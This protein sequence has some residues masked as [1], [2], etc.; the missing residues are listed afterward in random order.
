MMQEKLENI[1]KREVTF[2]EQGIINLTELRIFLEKNLEKV[3]KFDFSDA[4][5]KDGFAYLFYHS[6][7]VGIWA[8]KLF[9]SLSQDKEK[10]LNAVLAGF[11]HDIAFFQDEQKIYFRKREL[12][13]EEIKLIKSHPEKG[14]LFLLPVE[15][16]STMVLNGVYEHHERLDGSGYPRGIKGGKISLLGRVLAVC[17]VYDALQRKHVYRGA[18]YGHEVWVDMGKLSRN[19]LD[20]KVLKK[21]LE[22]TSIYPVGKK[23][24]LSNQKMAIVKKKTNNPFRPVVEVNGEIIDLTQPANWSIY[25]EKMVVE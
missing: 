18:K 19:Q 21:M 7:N 1:Y 25:I 24:K 4:K 10:I 2:W 9:K 14:M 8:G 12:G 3:L 17:D 16:L 13:R 5:I 11:L 6:L 20:G 23:I 22:L 15:K